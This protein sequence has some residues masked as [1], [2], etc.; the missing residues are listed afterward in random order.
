MTRSM[1]TELNGS[2]MKADQ[3]HSTIELAQTRSGDV[4]RPQNAGLQVI[5]M[6]RIEK[7]QVADDRILAESIDDRPAR[8][9]RF[10]S[11][12]KDQ[13]HDS[14]QPRAMDLHK[15]LDQLPGR[16]L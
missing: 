2:L 5:G 7:K 13:L 8:C 12:L 15:K 9:S 14:F 3:L 16:N 4:E 10:A 11:G 6:Q 1:K